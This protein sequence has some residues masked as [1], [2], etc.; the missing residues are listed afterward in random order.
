[1][2][3]YIILYYHTI[4]Y[5]NIEKNLDTIPTFHIAGGDPFWRW[6]ICLDHEV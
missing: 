1:M 4:L 5:K 6:F 3:Y 2:F